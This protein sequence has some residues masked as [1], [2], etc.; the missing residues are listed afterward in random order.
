MTTAHNKVNGEKIQCMLL[1][2]LNTHIY[3]FIYIFPQKSEITNPFIKE[4][5]VSPP[6]P[7][8]LFSEF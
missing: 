7:L 3:I 8:K 1:V 5:G 4:N 2:G 6:L